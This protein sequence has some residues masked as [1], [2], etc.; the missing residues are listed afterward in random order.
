M[1]NEEITDLVSSLKMSVDADA[2]FLIDNNGYMLSGTEPEG[3]FDLETIASLSAGNYLTGKELAK[4]FYVEDFQSFFLSSSGKID[5]LQI[6]GD[7]VFLA[8][9]HPQNPSL[10]YIVG[11]AKIVLKEI[12]AIY[13]KRSF[14]IKGKDFI[15][16]RGSG[17]PKVRQVQSFAPAGGKTPF[18]GIQPEA[19][20]YSCSFCNKAKESVNKLIVVPGAAICDECIKLGY[21]VVCIET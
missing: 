18:P 8:I 13:Q 7:K 21:E 3:K 4:L 15:I 12:L 6:G 5:Y 20:T 9:V 17:V 16:D 11:Q 1:A 14:D 10:D 2:I 19:K